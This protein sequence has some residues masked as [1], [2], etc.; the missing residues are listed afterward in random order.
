MHIPALQ[1]ATKSRVIRRRNVRNILENADKELLAM[2]A[3][4][5]GTGKV[6]AARYASQPDVNG[7]SFDVPQGDTRFW[8]DQDNPHH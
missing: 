3:L 7:G 6:S 4:A 8:Q 1:V 2:I 5:W